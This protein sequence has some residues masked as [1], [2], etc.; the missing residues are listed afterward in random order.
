LSTNQQEK[1]LWQ[2]ELLSRGQKDIAFEQKTNRNILITGFDPFFLDRHIDQSNPSGAAALAFDN[3]IIHNQSQSVEIESLIFPVRFEDFDKGMVEQLLTPYIRDKQIDMVITISMGRDD[4]DL[5]R[6]PG[7]RRSAKAP[8][9]LNVLTGADA[10]NP[11]V[12]EL[13]GKPL[14]GAEFLEFSL[15]AKVML[16]A[17]GN[18]RVNDNHKVKT[19][20]KS[21]SPTSLSELSDQISVSG[22]GGGYLSNEIS[23]RSLL[24]RDV[25]YPDLPAGHIH[26]P[27]FKGFNPDKTENII[28]QIKAMIALTI[29]EI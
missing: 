25:Y 11:L 5:E 14:K 6:F 23:Y 2:L 1:L 26:T 13:D 21:F 29:V 9:N 15:P 19:L 10:V 17:E 18:F 22:S 8:D 12:P 20:E 24:I 27:R 16:S 4:F 28:K 3:L 7:L